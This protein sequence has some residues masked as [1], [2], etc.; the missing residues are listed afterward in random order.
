[1]KNNSKIKSAKVNHSIR[2]AAKFV[3]T[4]VAKGAKKS[5]VKAAT[6]AKW[7]IFA[8]TD[9]KGFESRWNMAVKVAKHSNN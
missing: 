8:K 2:G 1:M 9:K 7:P 5:E 4:L 6:L 3:R